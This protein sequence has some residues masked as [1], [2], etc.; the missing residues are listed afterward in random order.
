MFTTT[1]ILLAN[2]SGTV[3]EVMLLCGSLCDQRCVIRPREF[4]EKQTATAKNGDGFALQ[5]DVPS[6]RVEKGKC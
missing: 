6:L 3:R 2:I 1:S 5:V 4:V